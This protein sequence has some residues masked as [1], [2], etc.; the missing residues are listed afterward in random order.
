MDEIDNLIISSVDD[1]S[2][3]LINLKRKKMSLYISPATDTN[4]KFRR[5]LA[6]L[7]KDRA[8]RY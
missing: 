4:N 5:Q 1:P 3:E 6:A 7:E 2:Q 8:L